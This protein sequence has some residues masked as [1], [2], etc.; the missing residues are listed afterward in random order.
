[1]AQHK[2]CK[3]FPKQ[4]NLHCE[5][6]FNP[7]IFNA[8]CR[9]PLQAATPCLSPIA[10][11]IDENTESAYSFTRANQDLEKVLSA[12][13][14]DVIRRLRAL[15]AKIQGLC[16]LSEIIP[17]A[18]KRCHKARQV[19]K[20][21]PNSWMQEGH[22]L[23]LQVSLFPTP[24]DWCKGVLK[25]WLL[26]WKRTLNCPSPN[27]PLAPAL[28][29]WL[30]KETHPGTEWKQQN[31]PAVAVDLKLCDLHFIDDPFGAAWWSVLFN[32]GSTACRMVNMKI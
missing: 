25:K 22:E 24:D 21:F 9:L 23:V 10:W 6:V 19:N 17:L 8:L 16:C 30:Q 28:P 31:A 15:L 27:V 11:K 12:Q 3:V 4:S 2:Y 18:S 7:S 13:W 32:A 1:M 29:I 14:F 5:H 26:H 20:Y